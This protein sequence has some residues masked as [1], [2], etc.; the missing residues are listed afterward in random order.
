MPWNRA[1]CAERALWKIVECG[2]QRGGSSALFPMRSFIRSPSILYAFPVCLG[3]GARG[4]E[5]TH[6][7]EKRIKVF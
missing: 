1:A 6:V 4:G 7:V 2:W 5:S 3:E